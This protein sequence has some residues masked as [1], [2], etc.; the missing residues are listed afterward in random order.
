[1]AKTN[2]P[3]HMSVAGQKKTYS[4]ESLRSFT[5]SAFEKVGVPPEDAALAAASLV[6]ADL[7]GVETHGISH[8]LPLHIKRIKIGLVEPRAN[9]VIKRERPSTVLLDGGNGLGQV[10]AGRAMRMAIEKA[11]HTGAAFV[12]ITNSNHFGACAYW[13]MMALPHDQIGIAM[14]NG[15]KLTAPWGGRQAML[16]TAPISVAI[17]GD[18]EG[19]VVLDMATTATTKGRVLLY[20]KRNLRLDPTWALDAIGRPTTDPKEALQGLLQPVGGY[21]GYG[22]ALVIELLSGI[23]TGGDWSYHLGGPLAEDFSRPTGV[24]SCFG[25]IAVDAYMEPDEFKAQV[26]RVIREIHE[27]PRAEGCERIY[28]P[29]EIEAEC[30]ARR[31]TEGIPLD[32][33]VVKR[34]TDM[35]D[36]LGVPFP[37][38]M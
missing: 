27:S 10:I 1:M 23:L 6:E 35:G 25:A 37:A 36:D 28:M 5:A 34:L 3:G 31:E 7:R 21:K 4:A 11:A 16:G 2:T 15:S 29:G 17:P 30:K 24:G 9:I 32:T 13:S 12:G 8:Y 14:T 18:R 38:E 20:D 33:D 22:L 19:S 26:D